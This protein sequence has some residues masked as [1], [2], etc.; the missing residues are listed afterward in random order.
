MKSVYE[1]VRAGGMDVHYKFTTVKMRDGDANIVRSE[2]LDHRD[3]TQLRKRLASWPKDVPM[4]M[5]ASFGWS[6]LADLMIEE[7]LMPQLSNCYKVEKMRKARGLAKTNCMDA[8]L[9]SLMPFEK[10]SWW[11]VWM[12][13]PEVR[14]LRE[15]MRFRASLVGV[16]TE[17]KNRISALF[18]RHG[19]VHEFSDLFGVSGRKFL[20]ELCRTGRTSEVVLMPG[21]VM[22]LHGLVELMDFVRSQLAHVAAELRRQ[23][24][25]NDDIRRLDGI[26]GIGLILAHTLMA[27]IGLI[28]RFRSHR[29]LANYSLLAPQA[30]DTGEDDGSKPIGRHLGIRG[31]HTLK[32]AFIEAARGA[33]R[34]GGRWRML[35]NAATEGG[36]KN[37]NRG[38]IKV[39]R[40]LVKVV[41]VVL[42]RKV[43][44]TDAPPARPGS[45]Q[46]RGD[47]A[48]AAVLPPRRRMKDFFGKSRSGTGQP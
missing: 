46:A 10:Q 26:P 24:D 27:E 22:T 14:D 37:L 35:F 23:L 41:F 17:T 25:R 45:V 20:G 3:R 38:Y 1:S 13:P 11:K 21:A 42:S 32:W 2:R 28:G 8:G 43:E 15:Q 4:V 40:E 12:A 29:A 5:E 44:Y 9:L 39:A 30:N 18:H 33:V 6:W 48:A 34:R 47:A 16:Q 36:Q 7:G 31:N 19:I